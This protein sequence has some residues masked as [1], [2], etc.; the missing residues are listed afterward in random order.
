MERY[1]LRWVAL[2]TRRCCIRSPGTTSRADRPGRKL[3]DTSTDET[4]PRREPI[5]QKPGWLRPTTSTLPVR[6]QNEKASQSWHHPVECEAGSSTKFARRNVRQTSCRKGHGTVSE[7][8]REVTRNL[9]SRNH[10]Q[11][12]VAWGRV[13]MASLSKGSRRLS[14]FCT[15]MPTRRKCRG[16]QSHLVSFA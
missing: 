4:V 5:A 10:F 1:K 9:K 8:H 13:C 2:H 15:R 7:R 16:K 3:V 11:W 12:P 6:E 14:S